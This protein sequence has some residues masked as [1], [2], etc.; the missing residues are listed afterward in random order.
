MLGIVSAP[1]KTFANLIWLCSESSLI[2]GEFPPPHWNALN[3]RFDSY[4]LECIEQFNAFQWGEN[5]PKINEDS[6]QRQIKFA[7]VLQ[8]ALTIPSI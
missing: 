7:K 2:F 5:S 4:A 1:C 6:K 8:G 3:Y